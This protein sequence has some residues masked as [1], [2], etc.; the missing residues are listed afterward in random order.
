MNREKCQKLRE[1]LEKIFNLHSAELKAEFG[2]Q[3]KVGKA[4]YSQ[5]EIGECEFKIQLAEMNVNGIAETKEAKNFKNNAQIFGF[6][7]SDFGKAFQFK[8]HSYKITGLSPRFGKFPILAT[9][10]DGKI[11]K[12]P[13]TSVLSKIGKGSSVVNDLEEIGIED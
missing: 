10:E 9:R 1:K 13:A 2:I 12:F 8:T 6:E 11:F 3:V 7:E 5:V 4:T